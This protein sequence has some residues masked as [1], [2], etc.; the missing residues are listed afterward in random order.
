MCWRVAQRRGANAATYTRFGGGDSR[1]G[2]AWHSGTP[3]VRAEWGF[4]KDQR[5]A[6]VGPETD[7]REAKKSMGAVPRCA[8]P[9][10][11]AMLFVGLLLG[12]LLGLGLVRRVSSDASSSSDSDQSPP[13]KTNCSTA[14]QKGGRSGRGTA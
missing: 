5:V 8:P 12:L 6:M 4:D 1:P 7:S 3:G 13:P 11:S 14:Q 9:S 10:T 2:E